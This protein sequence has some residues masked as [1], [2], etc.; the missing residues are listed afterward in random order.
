MRKWIAK[1]L[2]RLAVRIHSDEHSER[3]LILDEYEIIRCRVEIAGD[4]S[5]GVDSEYDLLPP[6]W[7]V[8]QF[9]DGEQIWTSWNPG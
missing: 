3:I 2:H 7:T 4:D 6:G 5:H 9:R 1:A 8:Q